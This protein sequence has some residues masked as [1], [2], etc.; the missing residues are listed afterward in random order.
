MKRLN[1]FF[2]MVILTLAIA[3]GSF[4]VMATAFA[5]EVKVESTTQQVVVDADDVELEIGETA[6]LGFYANGYCNVAGYHFTLVLPSN[7]TFSNFELAGVDKE[8]N[9]QY[10]VNGEEVSVI[11][12]SSNEEHIWSMTMFYIEVVAR[13]VG[14]GEIWFRNASIVDINAN[15]VECRGDSVGITV[16][17]EPTNNVIKGDVDGDE[18]VTVADLML[19]QR[20][21]IGTL[22]DEANFSTDAADV[23][24]DYDINLID[25]QHVQ[26]YLVGKISFEELQ[27]LAG[28]GG[29]DT[30]VVPDQPTGEIVYDVYDGANLLKEALRIDLSNWTTTF[31]YNG[32]DIYGTSIAMSMIDE[33]FSEG[34]VAFVPNNSSML[35]AFV[36]G[37]GNEVKLD[38]TMDFADI[39]KENPA[40][41]NS[42]LAGKYGISNGKERIGEVEI[43][44][45]GLFIGSA[46]FNMNGNQIYLNVNGVINMDDDGKTYAW[47]FGVA[48]KEI[49]IFVD[50]KLIVPVYSS[51]TQSI[52]I[53]YVYP[54]GFTQ[55]ITVNYEISEDEDIYSIAKMLAYQNQPEDFVMANYEVIKSI[56]GRVQIMVKS[57]EGSGDV[58]VPEGK[59]IM[60]YMIVSDGKSKMFTSMGNPPIASQEELNQM[61]LGM[62]NAPAETGMKYA[63]AYVDA[64]LT[65]PYTEDM[66]LNVDVLYISMGLTEDA[67]KLL[68]GM[69]GTFGV[70]EFDQ[71]N[72]TLSVIDATLTLNDMDSTFTF[73]M[74][75]KTITGEAILTG[76]S[77]YEGKIDYASITLISNDQIQFAGDID[78]TND[79]RYFEMYNNEDFSSYETKEELKEIAGEYTLIMSAGDMQMAT[80]VAE[81]KDNGVIVMNILYMK[82]LGSY[83][84]VMTEKGA[85]IYITAD[86]ETMP[87]TIDFDSKEIVIDMSSSMGGGNS[88]DGPS[89]GEI[90]DKERFTAT[91]FAVMDG[92]LIEES[93]TPVYTYEDTYEALLEGIYGTIG[94]TENVKIY[95]DSELKVELTQSNF[96]TVNTVYYIAMSMS[97]MTD[98]NG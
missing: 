39:L 87:G 12:N 73:V 65:I 46:M 81:L 33:E 10:S 67:G 83:E 72:G 77:Y 85:E 66:G 38:D 22:G 24:G 18:R 61:I 16:L 25:C 3:L 28:N 36:L 20:Y 91:I 94:S 40:N 2:V 4:S 13:E 19:M 55:V 37:D 98:V 97:D 96:K 78:F 45:N 70:K 23:N 53:H 44:E 63:G 26:R 76:G 42:K 48:Q 57:S 11:C 62:A 41:F 27:A 74:G 29:S 93:K 92:V 58:E 43:L 68:T 59:N 86:S 51:Q 79:V 21:V 47:L 95:L 64:E 60:F 1:K 17:G 31:T 82:Q 14:Y 50:S 71:E 80:C 69:G 90:V 75:D 9:F 49:E 89:S 30:P 7:V 84:I 54:D 34:A 52:E 56:D 88:T 8:A 15:Q 6:R 5:E 35:Y 32:E